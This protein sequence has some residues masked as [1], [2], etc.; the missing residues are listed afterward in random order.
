MKKTR[1]K[2]LTLAHECLRNLTADKLSLAQGGA[3]DTSNMVEAC[4]T[5]HTH[6]HCVGG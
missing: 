2:K 4:P 6:C 1:T 3:P 5:L